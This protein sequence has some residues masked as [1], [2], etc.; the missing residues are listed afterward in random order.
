MTDYPFKIVD[1]SERK[2]PLKALQAIHC[3]HERVYTSDK[4]PASGTRY[5]C[6]ECGM[7]S[8]YPRDLE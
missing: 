8:A 7:G 6:V 1:K 3:D 5:I 2:P 4:Y